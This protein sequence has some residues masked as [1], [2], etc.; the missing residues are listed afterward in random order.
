MLDHLAVEFLLLTLD[1]TTGIATQVGG[2]GVLDAALAFGLDELCIPQALRLMQ[3]DLSPAIC[4]RSTPQP[5][6][7]LPLSGFGTHVGGL[8]VWPT[9]GV[10][11]ASG[12]QRG[13]IYTLSVSGEQ[14]LIGFTNAGAPG[15][16]AFAPIPEPSS[17]SFFVGGPGPGLVPIGKSQ[18]PTVALRLEV[19]RVR[20]LGARR[21]GRDILACARGIEHAL[22]ARREYITMD[23]QVIYSMA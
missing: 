11:F 20:Q 14:Q 8:A 15:D 2:S 17:A 10:I 6:R 3:M 21:D 13:G 7:S 5:V 18:A 22:S 1:P 12:D 16:I 4:T 19:D 9:D 23:R